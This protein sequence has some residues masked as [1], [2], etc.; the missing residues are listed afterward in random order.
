[1]S[2]STD[3]I[4]QVVDLARGAYEA[5]LA[6]VIG[7]RIAGETG[8]LGAECNKIFSPYLEQDEPD[9]TA[10]LYTVYDTL[11]TALEARPTKARKAA[12]T[13]FRRALVDRLHHALYAQDG[14]TAERMSL[15]S[16]IAYAEVSDEAE[17]V[18]PLRREL[19]GVL[20]RHEDGLRSIHTKSEKER[21]QAQFCL[22]LWLAITRRDPQGVIDEDH[23]G[24]AH[25][26]IFWGAFKA[27]L[28]ELQTTNGTHWDAAEWLLLLYRG[29]LLLLP[30]DKRAATGFWELCRLGAQTRR[31]PCPKNEDFADLWLSLCWEMG[32][33]FS[34][35]PDIHK[36]H[37]EWG[38]AFQR[39]LL[40]PLILT[41][42]KTG[43]PSHLTR[44]EKV[45]VR[46]AL[47]IMEE[48]G[49]PVLEKHHKKLEF[50]DTDR[51][52]VEP[53][54]NVIHVDFDRLDLGELG[55]R[56]SPLVCG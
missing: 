37:Y 19:W 40:S 34:T 44:D 2:T 6:K 43:A 30:H 17:I 31:Q 3:F 24:P 9:Y 50:S 54:S 48:F 25:G 53:H 16:L 52:I 4:A 26:N 5:P 11:R 49:K 47:E 8:D 23:C 32:T 55:E 39:T 14:T 10:I 46:N 18:I 56:A 22:D 15:G 27:V 38:R 12:L 1:M 36:A 29:V 51:N 42:R 33:V 20:M 13:H 45:L 41:S 28:T 21:E 35:T 7:A